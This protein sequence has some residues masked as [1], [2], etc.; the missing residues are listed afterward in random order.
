MLFHGTQLNLPFRVKRK[1]TTI[2][3]WIQQFGFKL[4]EQSMEEMHS[5]M[6]RSVHLSSKKVFVLNTNEMMAFVVVNTNE[7]M[8]VAF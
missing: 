3:P 2:M 7:I 4:S 1:K 6:K 5:H 8:A